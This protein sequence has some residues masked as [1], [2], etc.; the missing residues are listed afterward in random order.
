MRQGFIETQQGTPQMTLLTQ[1]LACPATL[2]LA[3]FAAAAV[4]AVVYLIADAFKTP[5]KFRS[6]TRR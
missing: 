6:I 5:R 4:G 1:V 2:P 3:M